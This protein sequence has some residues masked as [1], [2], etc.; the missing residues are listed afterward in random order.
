MGAGSSRLRSISLPFR[1]VA[2]RSSIIATASAFA[3]MLVNAVIVVLSARAG[4]LTEIATYTLMTAV[5]AVLAVAVGGGSSLLYVSGDEK[6]RLAVRS[7][8][9]FLIFPSMTIGTVV[10]GLLYSDR[11]YDWL[12]MLSVGLVAIGNNLAQLQFGDLA[13]EMRFGAIAWLM[14]VSKVPALVLVATGTRMTTALVAA[15]IVQ[16]VAT[17]AA[18]GRSS[19]I[20]RRCLKQLSP[21]LVISAFRMSRNLFVYTLAETYSARAASV[22]LSVFSTPITMGCFGT[23]L[24]VYHAVRGS[25]QSGVR[26]S[27][28]AKA[29]FR[30]GLEESQPTGREVEVTAACT[31]VF[32]TVFLIVAAPWITTDLLRLPMPQATDWLRILAVAIP[33]MIVNMALA[34]RSIG[35]GEYR[36]AQRVSLIIAGWLTPMAAVTIPFFGAFGAAFSSLFSEAFAAALLGMAYLISRRPADLKGN[37]TR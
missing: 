22:A 19:W 14:V 29:R 2:G 18:L 9:V 32:A 33:F 35:D 24:A 4:E 3:S 28:V 17:E 11:G 7:Q 25:L 16:T 5:M 15:T 34:L 30:H 12:P 1:S 13:R 6:Q 26:V 20:R 21:A 8:W 23:V 27:M 31:A 36:N 37:L 10:T